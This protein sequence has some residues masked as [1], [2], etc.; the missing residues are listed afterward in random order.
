M[1]PTAAV[2]GT[3]LVALLSFAVSGASW[4]ALVRTG[5]PAIGYV[6]AAFALLGAKNAWKATYLLRGASVPSPV[7]VVFTLFD[8]TMVGL[9]AWP[10][11]GRRRA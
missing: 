8:V 2:L 9:I 3:S 4:R 10:L 11:L 1:A 5:N 7:E 6:V